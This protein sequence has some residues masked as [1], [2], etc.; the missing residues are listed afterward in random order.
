MQGWMSDLPDRE[1]THV[2]YAI[3]YVTAFN[4]GVPGHLDLVVIAHLSRQLNAAHQAITERDTQI[5]TLLDRIAALEH[6]T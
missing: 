6:H 5:V 4:H 2:L 3:N 1:H